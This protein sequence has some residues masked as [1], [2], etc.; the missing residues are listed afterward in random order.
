[1]AVGSVAADEQGDAV[2]PRGL[3]CSGA[4]AGQPPPP[5]DSPHPY[6]L[7]PAFRVGCSIVGCCRASV[8]RALQWRIQREAACACFAHSP[9][10]FSVSSTAPSRSHD[11]MSHSIGVCSACNARRRRR[12]RAQRIPRAPPLH[13]NAA[14]T[15]CKAAIARRR[16]ATLRHRESALRPTFAAVCQPVIAAAC[17]GILGLVV[18]KPVRPHEG[19][20]SPSTVGGFFK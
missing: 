13:A 19:R 2:G 16:A 3:Q 5:S 10:I 14:Q 12:G 17:C 8:A 7:L 9:A 4:R 1:M 18:P 15:A 20:D 6:H 11:R